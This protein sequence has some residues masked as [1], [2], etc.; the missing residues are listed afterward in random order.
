MSWYSKREESTFSRDVVLYTLKDSPSANWYY[1]IKLHGEKR[2]Y[3]QRSTKTDSFE[4]ANEVALEAWQEVGYRVKQG[5]RTL[6]PTIEQAYKSFVDE[7]AAPGSRRKYLD[8][9]NLYFSAYFSL[10]GRTTPDAI[11]A[12]DFNAYP[13]WRRNDS[14][15]HYNQVSLRPD[16]RRSTEVHRT[17]I[18]DELYYLRR[19]LKWCVDNDFMRSMPS[20]QPVATLTGAGRFGEKRKFSNHISKETAKKIRDTLKKYKDSRVGNIVND[21]SRVRLWYYYNTVG[22]ACIRPGT[23]SQNLRWKDIHRTLHKRYKKHYYRV[24]VKGK[25]N[26]PRWAILPLQYTHYI[27]EWR[28]YYEENRTTD[29]PIEECYIW[30]ELSGRAPIN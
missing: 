9:W 28:H 13:V 20:H 19:F 22:R 16:L 3:L 23:E 18:R 24:L 11:T 17:T 2:P 15:E 4:K 5:I 25:L 10:R 14:Y 21:W 8:K 30:G 1:R 12:Q 27:D 7:R 6:T 26:K 29:T